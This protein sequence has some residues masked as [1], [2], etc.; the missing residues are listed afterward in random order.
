MQQLKI[1]ANILIPE[2]YC[3]IK[4]CELELLKAKTEEK[5]IWN[6]HDL[7]KRLSKRNEWIKEKLLYNPLFKNQLD[8]F[9][10]GPVFYPTSRGESWAFLALEMQQFIE[11]HF[12]TI[13]TNGGKC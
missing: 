1:Q 10:G 7:E 3:I 5:T 4:K 12:H 13:F 11:T 9:N 6:M 2:E 8:S